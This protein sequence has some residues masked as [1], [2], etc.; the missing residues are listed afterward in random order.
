M[1]GGYDL[2]FDEAI[3]AVQAILKRG[4]DVEIRRKGDG[5]IVL[6]VKKTI[7]YSTSAQ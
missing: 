4:N 6:E 2:N 3:K 1:K 7:K 5:Y